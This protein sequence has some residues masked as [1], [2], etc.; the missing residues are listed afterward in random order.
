MEN[1]IIIERAD[2]VKLGKELRKLRAEQELTCCQLAKKAICAPA[3]VAV[4]ERALRH[5]TLD[6]I[7]AILE[8][9]GYRM[10][11][12]FVREADDE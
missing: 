2:P 7:K 3:T 1:K 12:T 9:L 6:T 4:V 8:G 10:D 5:S 11:I